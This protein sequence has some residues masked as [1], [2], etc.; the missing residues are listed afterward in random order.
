MDPSMPSYAPDDTSAGHR[1]AYNS[2]TDHR[3][4]IWIATLLCM[5]Y[6]LGS[7]LLRIYIKRHIFSWDDY[8]LT[9]SSI[10]A[11]CQF[12]LCYAALKRGAGCS[13]HD[14]EDAK[15]LGRIVFVARLLFLVSLYL[16]KLSV[17]AIL[18]RV[19]VRDQPRLKLLCSLTSGL[20]VSS[21][22][23]SIFASSVKCPT[24]A[25]FSN[26]H[27]DGQII[28]WQLA[29]AFDIVTEIAM[30]LLLPC[31]LWQVQMRLYMKM[32]VV[33]A[34]CSRISIVP[35]SIV[36]LEAWQDYTKGPPSSLRVS[37]ILIWQQILLAFSLITA[38]VPSLK[39]FLESLSTRWGEADMTRYGT[40]NHTWNGTYELKDLN[41]VESRV[42]RTDPDMNNILVSPAF[43]THIYT[44]TQEIGGRGSR[45]SSTGG[46]QDLIIKK[47]TTWNVVTT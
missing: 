35:I 22:F 11:L 12:C 42:T 16:A 2:A 6:T 33:L 13:L 46:S 20:I 26:K 43:E 8:L 23:G 36:Y 14:F 44:S 7:L 10:V 45:A 25:L 47:E 38:T 31:L 41:G 37:Q 17:L 19:F 39:S 5:T 18:C 34:F 40:S 27:C 9:A 29:T 15:V 24:S 28:R 21:A 3:G 30:L 4:P 1:F 32:H